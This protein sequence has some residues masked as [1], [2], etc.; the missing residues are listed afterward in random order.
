MLKGSVSRLRLR[1]LEDLFDSGIAGDL[2]DSELLDRFLRLEGPAGEAAFR[3]LVERHGQMV[4]RVCRQTLGDH[5]AAQDAAQ[6]TFLVL[7]RRADAIR[8]RTSV[9]SWLFGV[10]R[11]AAS[12]IRME[13]ARRRQHESRSVERSVALIS[14]GQEPV[15]SDPYPELHAEIDRLPEKYRL[16]IVLCYLEG[17]TH[18]QAASRLRWPVGTVK[19]RLSRGRGRLRSRLEK[20]GRPSLLLL[21]ANA[22]RAENLAELPDHVVNAITQAGCSYAATGDTGGLVSR[23]VI[24]VSHGVIKSMLLHKLKVTGTVA[25]GLF[26]LGFGALVAAQQAT[27]KDRAPQAARAIGEGDDARFTLRVPGATEIIPHMVVQIHPPLDCRIDKVLVALGQTIKP[28]DPLVEL[29][30]DKLAEAKSNYVAAARKHVRDKALFDD[31]ANALP[32][33]E[34][35][36]V[37]K[38]EVVSGQNMLNAKGV[39]VVYGLSEQEIEDAGREEG[40]QKARMVLR[41]SGEGVVVQ[42]NVVPGNFYN[43]Y[44]VLMIIARIDDLWARG[45]VSELDAK[46]VKFGQEVTVIFPFADHRVKAK[47]EHVNS[48]VDRATHTVEIRTSIPNPDHRYKPGMAVS[49]AIETEAGRDMPPAPRGLADEPTATS[50]T[51][52]LNALE[53]KL[54]RLLGEK[55]ERLSH[56]K[57][58]DRLDALERKMDQLLNGRR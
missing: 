31:K 11:R 19:T 6:A 57:I 40:A 45:S 22:F 4:F 38:N 47:V 7:A 56:A 51:D 2:S 16:P 30:S 55:E 18:E 26:L 13:E 54:D 49:M 42:R 8:K 39:L 32:F 29:S 28:G 15:D 53:R 5:H 9:S 36:E 44:D 21:P 23:T 52:R 48:Q 10:A 1:R 20:Q 14:G 17:L 46:R 43:S 35:F 34:Y 58:L 25:A 50:T 12:R 33:N 37:R 27:G 41:S 3:S 24:K